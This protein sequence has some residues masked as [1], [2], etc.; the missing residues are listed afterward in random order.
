MQV[1]C[2]DACQSSTVSCELRGHSARRVDDQDLL[3]L[4][5]KSGAVFELEIFW[6][7]DSNRLLQEEV[8]TLKS[9]M[10]GLKA[11]CLGQ[12]RCLLLIRRNVLRLE[13][14]GAYVGLTCN[15]I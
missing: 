5:R 11:W 14:P 7:Q 9:K 6:W 8:R 1:G 12:R 2:R 10:L 15:A 13:G 4:L 3:G